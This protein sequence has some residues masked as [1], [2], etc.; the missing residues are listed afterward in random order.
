MVNNKVLAKFLVKAKI[1]TYASN[2]E[3]AEKKLEN[4][5]RELTFEE[6]EFSYR[7][8]YFG[9]NPFAGEEVV[10]ENK[11][12]IWVMNYCGKIISNDVTEKE[13]YKFLQKAMKMVDEENPFRGPNSLK[14]G[15]FEYSDS[16]EGDINFFNGVEK[17]FYCGKLV[18]RLHYHGGL[19]KLK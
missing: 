6:G 7:D 16:N 8:I 10:W 19:V 11:K 14:E 15:N 12:C 18:Y 9:F 1:R 4:G 17:I 5:G 3:G 2:G 13:I